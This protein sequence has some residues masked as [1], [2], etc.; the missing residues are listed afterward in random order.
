MD[1]MW[2]KLNSL[3]SK[4]IK[5]Y[6]I[7]DL[8]DNI[9][10]IYKVYQ[11]DTKVASKSTLERFKR[12]LTKEYDNL[13]DYGK[14]KAK[15]Y[16]KATRLNNNEIAEF[17][18]YITY[19]KQQKS[20]DDIELNIATE[21]VQ[22]VYETETEKISKERGIKL[23]RSP[24]YVEYAIGLLTGVNAS[25]YI[26]NE[27]KRAMNLYNANETYRSLLINEE[28]GLEELLQRQKNRYLKLKRVP[29]KD[30]KYIGA[31]EEELVGIANQTK[32][33]AY[34][35]MRIQ[36]VRFVGIEDD[37][38]TEMCKSLDG[39]EFYTNKK[40]VYYR[41]SAGDK[42][43]VQYTTIGL[44]LG[45]NLPPINNHTH[46]CRSTIMYI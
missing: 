29:D 38:Q 16:L 18:L 14:F 30:D 37:R 33:K 24:L 22:Y 4:Y 17:V 28:K 21:L 2:Q 13:D 26:W 10:D 8:K 27:Y 40:N 1:K 35:D 42:R 15:Q 41:Y 6:S 9:E 36:K 3:E 7:F 43:I 5:A 11:F 32:L 23:P 39:Q 20:L 46:A 12:L 34:E 31:F 19:T 44:K 45:E 25:G